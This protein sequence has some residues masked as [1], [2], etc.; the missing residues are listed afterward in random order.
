M[1]ATP[2][3]EK[4]TLELLREDALCVYVSQCI[5]A[6]YVCVL[7]CVTVCCSVLQCVA[8]CC[9]VLQCVAVWSSYSEKMNSTCLHE[10][11]FL[12]V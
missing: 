5:T 8:V 4:I 7:Q 2:Y 11:H 6:L 9:S 10:I 12:Q 1:V 3:P